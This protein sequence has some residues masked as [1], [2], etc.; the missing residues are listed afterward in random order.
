MA[1]PPL[2]PRRALTLH[3][4]IAGHIVPGD[5]GQAVT[6]TADNSSATS[7]DVQ[8][9]SFASVTSTD[10]TCNA[11]LTA[12]GGQ[13]SMADVTSNTVVPGNATGATLNGSGT[14]FWNDEAYAQNVCAGKNLTLNVTSN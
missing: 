3:A 11:F 10:S 5:G 12:N 4:N 8:T 6:F 9:I 7:Q 14:L 13:F 1:A 2:A